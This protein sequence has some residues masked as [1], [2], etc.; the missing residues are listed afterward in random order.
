M[1]FDAAIADGLLSRR[2]MGWSETIALALAAV[3]VSLGSAAWITDFDQTA[4]ASAALPANID[5]ISS[6]EDR[7]FPASTPVSPA[8][9]AALQPLDRSGSAVVEMKVRAAKGLLDPRLMSRDSRAGFVDE[10]RVDEA[11]ATTAAAVP[12]PR[13]RPAAEVWSGGGRP[14]GTARIGPGSS[15][16]HGAA[17]RSYAVAKTV[18]PAAWKGHAGLARAGRR[19]VSPGAGPRVARLRWVHCRLRHLGACRLPT[20]RFEPRGA[21]GNGQ[22]EGRSGTCFRAQRRRDAAGGL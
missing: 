4:L 16:Q 10:A 7:F 3:A 6:F 11:K 1:A 2:G 19:V 20:E 14:G 22:S 21:L 9:T 13:S 17:G 12:L 5:R 8:G 18:R 15:R